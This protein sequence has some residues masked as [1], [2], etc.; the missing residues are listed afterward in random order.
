MAAAQQFPTLLAQ[1][2]QVAPSESF[3]AAHA[4]MMQKI[5]ATPAP[6]MA[7]DMSATR[8]PTQQTAPSA[9]FLAAHTE[10][11]RKIGLDA[12]DAGHGLQM[13][14]QAA[15]PVAV[16]SQTGSVSQA[17]RQLPGL[18]QSGPARVVHDPLA[19]K[20]PAPSSWHWRPA[21]ALRPDAA[22]S[23]TPRHK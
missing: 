10:M 14:Q 22:I 8:L 1:G 15:Q 23:Q 7:V 5:N 11:L 19:L 18:R 2:K 6:Q 21:T 9:E 16:A 3:A 17:Q 13:C 4:E 12:Q 20:A